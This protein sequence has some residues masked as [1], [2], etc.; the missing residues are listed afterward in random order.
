[1]DY[2]TEHKYIRYESLSEFRSAQIR[3][4]C[5]VHSQSS[6]HQHCGSGPG[7]NGIFSENDEVGRGQ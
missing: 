5:Q 4:V 1:M 2:K 7:D 3:V 6:A